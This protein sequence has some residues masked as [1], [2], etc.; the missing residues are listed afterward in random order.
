MRL[1]VLLPAML[2]AGVLVALAIW[3]SGL[4][5]QPAAA[6]SPP[7]FPTVQAQPAM[8]NPS[9]RYSAVSEPRPNGHALPEADSGSVDGILADLA[10]P[11]R[12]IHQAAL[13]RAREL[14]DRSIIPQLRQIAARAEDGQE[15]ADIFDTIDYLNLPSVDETMAEARAARAAQGLP[16]PPQSPTNRWTGQPFVKR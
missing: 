14:D 9:A 3:I 1:K 2:L 8:A 13:R 6:A 15:K 12:E 11:G 5:R 7:S 4:A 16:D 10:K